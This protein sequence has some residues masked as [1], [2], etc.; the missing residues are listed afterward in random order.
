MNLEEMITQRVVE[1][2]ERI[3]PQIIA[4]V[5]NSVKK[6]EVPTV[7]LIRLPATGFLR[8]EQILQ[9]IPI[10]PTNWNDRVR[11]G[12]L[13]QPAEGAKKFFGNVRVW[14]AEDIIDL[15]QMAGVSISK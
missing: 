4:T 3:T 2:I 5:E 14:R 11:D 9:F 6:R 7:E 13:P 12:K 8:Q 1:I 15:I 10:G